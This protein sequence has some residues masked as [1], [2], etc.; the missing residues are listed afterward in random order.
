MRLDAR[1]LQQIGSFHHSPAL[2][3]VVALGIHV[4]IEIVLH[5]Q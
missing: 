5:A 1:S 2:G 4:K 3:T